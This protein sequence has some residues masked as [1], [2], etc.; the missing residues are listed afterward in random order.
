MS[1]SVA[2]GPASTRR[3]AYASSSML[4]PSLA[5][6]RVPDVRSHGTDQF[7]PQ[8]EQAVTDN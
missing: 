3:T 6:Y 8:L 1:A 2:S 4:T 7:H 5:F